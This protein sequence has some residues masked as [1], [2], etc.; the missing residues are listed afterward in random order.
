[1][2]LAPGGAYTAAVN[3]ASSPAA[4]PAPHLAAGPA[5]AAAEALIVQRREGLYCPAGDFHIDP[6]KPV[7]R[8]VVT[9]AHGDHARKGMGRYWCAASGLGLVRE[10]L[11]KAVSIKALAYGEPARFGRT[12]VTLHPAGHMLGSA[13]VRIECDGQVWVVSGDYKREADP[14]CEPF[15]P[16]RCDVFVTETT[17]A[18]PGFQWPEPAQVIDEILAWW[19]DCAARGDTAVLFA[20]AAG[21]AQRVLAE[22]HGRLPQIAAAGLN[23]LVGLHPTMTR[24]VRVYR[25]GGVAMLPTEPVGA[26][27]RGSVFAGR[28]ILA[29]PGAVGTSWMN[30]FAPHA[31]GF[32]S[33][34][35]GAA[36]SQRRQR[37]NAGFT[38]SDH[39]D[40]PSL[41]R[42]I[43]ETG[44]RRVLT[45]HGDASELL[46][47]LRAEGIVCGELH[48]AG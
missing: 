25:A 9:H 26:P 47:P 44:A 28:L 21:K 14:S 33:G 32:A 42:T 4:I 39:A 34:W 13:Q 5:P 2:R 31:T 3:S 10:R 24:M 18:R 20:Y 17:F 15:E 45:M 23:P 41:L 30:R 12:T 38:L 11:G 40:W 22:L 35:M 8:A 16:Q 48:E 27:P 1:M 43:R 6:C 29:P 37:Y 36:D 46:G 19:R 7:P